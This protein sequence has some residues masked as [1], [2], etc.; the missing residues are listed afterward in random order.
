MATGAKEAATCAG[1][2]GEVEGLRVAEI[3]LILESSESEKKEAG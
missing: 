1:G 2:I 3:S